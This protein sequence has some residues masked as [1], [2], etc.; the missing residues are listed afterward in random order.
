MT[1][2]RRKDIMC[3]AVIVVLLFCFYPKLFML[4]GAWLQSDYREQHFPWANHLSES[5]KEG[6]I[7]FWTDE[8]ESGFPLVAEGQIAAFYVPNLIFYY[9]LPIRQAYSFNLIFHLF[10][11]GMMMFFLL[12][13]LKLG[14]FASLFGSAVYLFGSTFGGAFYNINSLKVLCWLPVVLIMIDLIIRER[15]V[16]HAVILIFA[17]T[18]MLLAGYLQFAVYASVFAGVYFIAKLARRLKEPGAVKSLLVVLFSFLASILITLPQHL[19]TYELYSR[20]VRSGIGEAFSYLGS[21]SPLAGICFFI[22]NL[23][24]VFSGKLYMGVI[25][26]FFF[27]LGIMFLIRKKDYVFPSLAL[28]AIL[29]ALGMFSPLYVGLVKALKFYAFRIPMKFLMFFGFFFS[30]VTAYGVNFLK[31]TSSEVKKRTGSAVRWFTALAAISIG[32]FLLMAASLRIFYTTVYG[33]GSA[34][35]E[36][37]IYARPGHPYS[38]EHYLDKLEGF[39]GS[40]KGVLDPL[41]PIFFVPLIVVI[42]SLILIY[43]F[44]RGILSVKVFLVLALLLVVTDLHTYTL[45]PSFENLRD[46]EA[47]DDY[48]KEPEVAKFLKED[49]EK[50]RVFTFSDN[51]SGLPLVANYNMVFDIDSANVYSPLVLKRYYRFFGEMGGINDSS[52]TAPTSKKYLYSHLHQLGMMNVKYILTDEE[53]KDGA[54]KKVY[55]ENGLRVYKN[56]FHMPRYW[57]VERTREIKEDEEL[58]ASV[59]SPDFD[60]ARTAYLEGP[61]SKYYG[62]PGKAN[63]SSLEVI[64]E[65]ESEILLKVTAKEDSVLVLSQTHYPGWMARVDDGEETPLVRVN[66]LISGVPVAGGEHTVRIYYKPDILRILQDITKGRE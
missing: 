33:I 18:Q 11:S 48:F 24:A 15:K 40:A 42:V 39:L 38:L 25:S 63:R 34:L 27:I 28:V 1:F 30:I 66:Y 62:K 3:L 64:S 10:F 59:Q 52:G 22:P 20:S 43:A 29:L 46:Y 14:R 23:D 35:I 55:E 45:D 5:L 13:H 21:F 9:F 41:S 6:R 54:L 31:E 58:F 17:L 12:R 4:K 36:K 32:I 49:R 7:P 60:P 19:L 8:I 53:L 56:A 61:L 50:Y 37:Y 51:V 65:K 16:L 44:R 2:L 26:V 57:I 47:Y